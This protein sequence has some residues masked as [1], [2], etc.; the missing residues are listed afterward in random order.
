MVHSKQD[1]DQSHPRPHAVAFL[2]PVF[3]PGVLVDGWI[4]L[5]ASGKGMHDDT[6]P[7]KER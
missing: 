7:F 6:L 3:C 2:A 1:G 5:I 4:K